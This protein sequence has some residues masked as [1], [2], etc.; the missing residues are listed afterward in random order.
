MCNS[1]LRILIFIVC[2]TL[3]W[4][5]FSG[6]TNG[7]V[8]VKGGRFIERDESPINYWLNVGVYFVVGIGGLCFC[9]F[10]G[11]MR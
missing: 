6:L 7:R 10:S 2:S 1:T 4:F 9:L 5:G 3:L 11:N 8:Y